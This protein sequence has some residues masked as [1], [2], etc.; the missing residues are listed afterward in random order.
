ME[1][2]PRGPGPALAKRPEELIYR[3]CYAPVD[4]RSMLAD[5]E[6]RGR[7][8]RLP[9]VQ[10]F[11]S[12]K[13]L[14][15]DEVAQLLPHLTEEQWTAILDL[16]VWQK[17]RFRLPA[18]LGWNRHL[19]TTDAP[20]ARKL[21]R[22]TA[23]D[24]WELVFAKG[25]RIHARIGPDEFEEIAGDRESM[26]TPD[27][28]FLVEFRGNTEQARVLRGLLLRL[29][30]LDPETTAL[31]LSESLVRTKSELEE[32]A[33]QNRRQRVEDLGFPDYFDALDIYTP[34]SL[35]DR[36]L[37]KPLPGEEFKPTELPAPSSLFLAYGPMLLFRC[38]AA[39]SG[40]GYL[41][42]MVEELFLLCNRVMAA[43]RVPA[44]DPNRIRRGIRK[45]VCGV[46]L[47]LSLWSEDMPGR[48]IEGVK[49]HFLL[50]FFQLG[51][52]A[53][54]ELR[55]QAR[56]Q[57]QDL[58]AKSLPVRWRGMTLE[59]PVLL[60]RIGTRMK[61]RFLEDARDVSA[62]KLWLSRRVRT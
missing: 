31:L 53:L 27:G 4:L 43:D 2:D 8:R 22:A 34:L 40:T 16:D 25:L 60:R 9:A 61:F 6:G 48:A 24:V 44:G 3:S 45:V 13:E 18:I 35:A 26:V 47:G 15:D 29:Y 23:P 49:N 1:T 30:E 42:P 56:R 21:S 58:P 41:E 19:L 7:I 55:E 20:V 10:L 14:D 12:L 38:L 51:Y 62:A 39:C 37:Q 17:D 46:N 52:G 57:A 32:E 28:H 5:A 50:Q 11:F 36:L 59:Y 54:R 33:F